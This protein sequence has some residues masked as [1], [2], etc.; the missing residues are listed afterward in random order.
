MPQM[1]VA[2]NKQATFDA[3]LTQPYAST[4]ASNTVT[5]TSFG[6]SQDAGTQVTL[7][8]QI[9]PAGVGDYLNLEYQISLSAFVGAAPTPNLPPPR[10]QNKV[11]SAA[12]L[13]DGYTVVVGG[14][15]LTTEGRSTSQI[16]G[17]GA[18]PVIGEAFK[19][20]NRNS[21]HNRFFVFIRANILRS[22]SFEDL[23]YVSDTTTS[24]VGVDDGFP[25]VEPRVIR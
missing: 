21:G 5:T 15:D 1:L 14:I 20:R 25:D 11:Q 7:K 17:L 16:P 10:Q 24:A 8:P 9:A 6:G 13:P 23:K 2:N 4:N 3:I 18:I 19:S 12:S 22:S